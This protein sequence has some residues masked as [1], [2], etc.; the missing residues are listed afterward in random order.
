MS[1][2]SNEIAVEKR[3]EFGNNASRRARKAGM[4]PAIVYSKG[5]ENQAFFVDADAWKVLS[6]HGAHM[7]TLV[8]GE[9]KIPALVREVQF[10][11]LKNYVLHI[12]FQQIDLDHEITDA[13]PVHA[14]GD[15]C[16]VA[17]G[18]ILEQEIHSLEVTCRPDALPEVIKVDVSALDLNARLHVKELVLP[19]GVRTAA[20]P[21][22][23]VFHVILPKQ[24]AEPAP[25]AAAAAEPEA[26]KEKAGKA[27]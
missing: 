21:D 7:V 9:T 18:G 23:V 10:N 11:H 27:E 6:G 1:K 13:V 22:T 17:H 16:G 8:D 26:I 4:I 15:C 20:D 2:V 3:N 25:A 14:T 19:E 5:K 12:D 24:E